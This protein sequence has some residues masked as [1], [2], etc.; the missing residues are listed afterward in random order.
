MPK[1][2]KRLSILLLLAALLSGAARERPDAAED[3]ARARRW[4]SHGDRRA[5]AT[6]ASHTAGS[7]SGT[8][9]SLRI[10]GTIPQ[11]RAF[12]AGDVSRK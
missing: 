5:P 6:D 2:A 11:S 9:P 10:R 12:S 3:G 4:W 7:R 1:L 8:L